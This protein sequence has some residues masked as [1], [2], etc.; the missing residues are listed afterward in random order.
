MA[1]SPEG[2][3]TTTPQG[4]DRGHLKAEYCTAQ[5]AEYTHVINKND[6]GRSM[7]KVSVRSVSKVEE[8]ENVFVR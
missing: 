6:F 4:K 2:S 7:K 5:N 3:T 1:G 8:R